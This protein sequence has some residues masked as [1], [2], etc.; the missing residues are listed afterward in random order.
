[1]PSCSRISRKPHPGVL[2]V[3]EVK[4][5][6]EVARGLPSMWRRRRR[7]AAHH[8]D[9]HARGRERGRGNRN[10]P[11]FVEIVRYRANVV[12][13]TILGSGKVAPGLGRCERCAASVQL[14]EAPGGLCHG[15]VEDVTE[16][17]LEEMLRCAAE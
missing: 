9:P 4:G 1:M 14:A 6:G 11:Q 3:D 8:V 16:Q 13:S 15:C 12:G 7:V 10:G 5:R 2:G 17:I